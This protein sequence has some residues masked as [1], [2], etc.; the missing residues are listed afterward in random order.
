[1]KKMFCIAWLF[2]FKISVAQNNNTRVIIEAASNKIDQKVIDWRRDIHEHP[3]LGNRELR[4]AAL[5]AK[6]P[7][8]LGMEVKTGVGVTGVIGP[9]Q[10]YS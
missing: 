1:M 8:S 5:V 9:L 4:T 3:E 6:H 10:Y 7:Q 2:C